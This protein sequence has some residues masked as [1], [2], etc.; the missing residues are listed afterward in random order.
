MRQINISPESFIKKEHSQEKL[1]IYRKDPTKIVAVTGAVFD[2][3]PS[4]MKSILTE[5]Y[6]ER[7]KHKRKHLDL[8]IEIQKL[9]KEL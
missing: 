2:K 4:A 3:K 7:K 9:K 5:L 8:E 6:T 1:E